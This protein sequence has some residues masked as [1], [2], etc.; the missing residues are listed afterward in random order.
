QDRAVAAAFGIDHQRLGLLLGGMAGA[1]AAVAG[2]VFA[3]GNSITP[4]T[5]YDWF[6]TVFAVVILGGIG[7]LL[8]TLLAGV[9]VGVLSGL[10]S[11]IWSPS[12][13]PFVLFLAIVLA[14]LLRPQ[15]LF[16]RRVT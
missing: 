9:G 13:E 8:G 1:S 4:A 6:G 2:A 15:G 3:L 14:L 7:N 5:P 11:A 10:V 16:T 12:T